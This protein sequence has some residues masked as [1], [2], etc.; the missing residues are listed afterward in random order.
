[1]AERPVAALWHLGIFFILGLV[2]GVL[3]S[4][5]KHAQSK[6]ISTA[7]DAMAILA[8]IVFS[9]FSVYVYLAI[10]VKRWHEPGRLSRPSEHPLRLVGRPV[11]V[12]IAVRLGAQVDIG[13]LRHVPREA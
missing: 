13:I 7:F 8:L 4:V 1:M 3:S 9:L 11:L 12:H 6:P 5:L 2:Y 10:H